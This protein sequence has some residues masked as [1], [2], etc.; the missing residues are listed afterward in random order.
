M[1]G[2]GQ[3]PNHHLDV[4]GHTIEVLR[5]LLEVEGDLERYAGE[6]AAGGRGAAR[7]SRS[8]TG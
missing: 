1:R 5:A 3:N 4:H 2:V 7:T 8:P 6:A